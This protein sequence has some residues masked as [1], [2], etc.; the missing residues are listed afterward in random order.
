MCI[1]CPELKI[2]VERDNG[3]RIVI[4]LYSYL[5]NLKHVYTYNFVNL[6]SH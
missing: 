6:T 5:I 3:I 2:N 1:V 4:F